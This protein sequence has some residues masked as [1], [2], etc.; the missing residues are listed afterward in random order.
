MLT[1]LRSILRNAA[2]SLGVERAANAA[3]IEEMWPDVI[4]TS[5]AA[6]S[7]V[8]GLRGTV[9]L[10]EADAGLWAQELSARRGHVIA[11]INRRLG[12]AVVT[13]IRFRQTT[14]P[15]APAGLRS[16]GERE[17]GERRAAGAEPPAGTRAGAAALE[18][19]GLSA[20]E[21]DAVEGV[22]AE[23]TDP[24]LRERARRAMIS[25][26]KWRRDRTE[27]EGGKA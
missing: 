26:L 11:E 19:E 6:H 3:L 10:A 22:V 20:E 18:A 8:L 23:I 4:G 21:K 25:Q 12:G 9:L 15:V 7:R 2:R 27:E 17:E 16:A 24:E 13:E 5:A 1:S 14:Q